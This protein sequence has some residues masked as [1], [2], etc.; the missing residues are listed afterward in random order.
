MQCMEVK[1]TACYEFQE[2]LKGKDLIR[3]RIGTFW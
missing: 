3:L 2:L 1:T